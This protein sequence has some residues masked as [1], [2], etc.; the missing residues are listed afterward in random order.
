LVEVIGEE[1]QLGV[2]PGPFGLRREKIIADVTQK[3][4]LHYVNLMHCDARYFSPRLI[5][6]GV[7]VEN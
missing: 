3:L 2:P 7:I 4:N 1:A 6:V 5:G